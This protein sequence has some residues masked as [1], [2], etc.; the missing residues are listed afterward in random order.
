MEL[1]HITNVTHYSF[2][3]RALSLLISLAWP[4]SYAMFY[5]EQV[6][7][8]IISLN[9]LNINWKWLQHIRQQYE[10]SYCH[11]CAQKDLV[12]FF[13]W[14]LHT[15]ICG[16]Y[17]LTSTSIDKHK[18]DQHNVVINQILLLPL[19]N[20]EDYVCVLHDYQVWVCWC[21]VGW[22]EGLVG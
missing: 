9:F 12:I 16:M 10:L 20:D 18:V 2:K 13:R 5:P 6:N 11:K 17:L 14:W 21:L 22:V 8:C 1:N 7:S 19:P 4:V 3:A 15:H